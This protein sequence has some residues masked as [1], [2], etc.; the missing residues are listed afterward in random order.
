M[1]CGR[2]RVR[3]IIIVNDVVVVAIIIIIIL[4]TA[5]VEVSSCSDS[6][7]CSD[8]HSGRSNREF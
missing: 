4:S 2:V 3:I 1:V 6:G 8:R 7:S 5:A